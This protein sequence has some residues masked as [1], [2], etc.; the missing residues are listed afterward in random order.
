M[1]ESHWMRYITSLVLFPSDEEI[2]GC[3]IIKMI[4]MIKAFRSY[5]CTEDSSILGIIS[6]LLLLA[7]NT[8]TERQILD[9]IKQL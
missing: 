9:L 2:M 8:K 4:N 5:M 7:S 6:S 3:L 1:T